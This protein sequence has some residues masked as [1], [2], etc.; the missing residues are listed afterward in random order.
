MPTEGVSLPTAKDALK[1]RQTSP[2]FGGASKAG[3]EVHRPRTWNT[4]A[5]GLGRGGEGG[6]GADEVG[7][8]GTLR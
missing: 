2:P 5:P 8:G 1:R 4:R 6:E 7:V 3:N